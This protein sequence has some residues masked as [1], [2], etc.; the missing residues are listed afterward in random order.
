MESKFEIDHELEKYMPAV[1]DVCNEALEHLLKEAGGATTPLIVWD[2]ANVLLDGH[3]RYRACLKLGLPYRVERISCKDR[4]E[5]KK[6]MDLIQF[7]RRNVSDHDQAVGEAR[8]L[9]VLTGAGMSVGEAVKAIAEHEGESERTTFR[10]VQYGKAFDGLE[11]HWQR[12]LLVIDAPRNQVMWISGLGAKRRRRIFPYVSK[13]GATELHKRYVEG[14]PKK[15][16]RFGTELPPD[17]P[18]ALPEL[19]PRSDLKG[20]PVTRRVNRL[21]DEIEE[22]M[23]SLNQEL[24]RLFGDQGIRAPACFWKRRIDKSYLEI[25]SVLK[26]VRTKFG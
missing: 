8:T 17:L 14:L 15:L 16:P 18:P 21:I 26:E 9:R 20:K 23:K 12:L 22:S 11:D 5:A 10:K 7:S 3:R 24:Y 6:K 13:Y 2:E 4:A 19:I 1:S 25:K